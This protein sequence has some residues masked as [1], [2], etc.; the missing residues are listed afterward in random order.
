MY[1][2]I[3]KFNNYVLMFNGNLEMAHVLPVAHVKYH[4]YLNGVIDIYG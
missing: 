3:K 2:V 1:I 4:K